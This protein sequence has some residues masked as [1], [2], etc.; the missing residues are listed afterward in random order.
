[1]ILL[2]FLLV[3]GLFLVSIYNGLIRKKNE[4]DNAFGGIDVQLKKRYDLIPNLVS[5]VQQYAS[6]EKNYLKKLPI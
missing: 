6:H 1:M 3:I 5:T 4:V 2:I